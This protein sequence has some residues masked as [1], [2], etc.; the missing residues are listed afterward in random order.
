MYFRGETRTVPYRDAEVGG[1]FYDRSASQTTNS[2][3]VVFDDLSCFLK[4][5]CDKKQTPPPTSHPPTA[6]ASEDC[7]RRRRPA[8]PCSAPIINRATHI[9]NPLNNHGKN[10][11]VLKTCK[12]I[13]TAV[14]PKHTPNTRKSN[15]DVCAAAHNRRNLDIFVFHYGPRARRLRKRFP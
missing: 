15:G 13:E 5:F 10:Y 1:C 12:N 7:K 11:R 2:N 8:P 14:T 4:L 6:R 3:I 9:Q